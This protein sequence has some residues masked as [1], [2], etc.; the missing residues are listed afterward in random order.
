MHQAHTPTQSVICLLWVAVIAV[1]VGFVWT[2]AQTGLKQTNTNLCE[3][4][5]SL[6]LPPY[7]TCEFQEALVYIWLAAAPLGAIYIF[8]EL[9]R[10][11]NTFKN[12]STQLVALLALVIFFVAGSGVSIFFA[13]QSMEQIACG[14]R[15]CYH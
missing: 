8:F 10:W 11:V 15:D 5:R 14:R 1:S 3:L 13:R 9:Y 7:Q 12:R 4:W 2:V 6:P